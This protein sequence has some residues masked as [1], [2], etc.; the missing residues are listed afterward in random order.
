MSLLVQDARL[1]LRLARRFPLFT[2]VVLLTIALGVGATTAI[3]SAV[4]AVML[5]PLP[6]ADGDRLVSLWGTNPD[7]SIPRFGVSWPDF[8]DWKQRAH[9]FDDMSIYVANVT[10]LVAPEGPESV[11]CLYVSSNF[12]DV[13]GIKPTIGRGFGADDERGE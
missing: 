10:T 6:F 4:H 5:Q 1:A 2:T 7:K 3:F 13:L 8:R 9:S 12:L 11:A